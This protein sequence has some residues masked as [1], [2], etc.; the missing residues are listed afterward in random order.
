MANVKMKLCQ[1]EAEGFSADSMWPNWRR[2][3]ANKWNEIH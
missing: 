1:G 2:K 3:P